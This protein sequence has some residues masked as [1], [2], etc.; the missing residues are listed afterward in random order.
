MGYIGYR[1][2]Q[3]ESPS[4]LF[5]KH[6]V[7]KI[8]SEVTVNGNVFE[9]SKIESAFFRDAFSDP[10]LRVRLFFESALQIMLVNDELRYGLYIVETFEALYDRTFRVRPFLGKPRYTRCHQGSI[11]Q[12]SILLIAAYQEVR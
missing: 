4:C 10:C 1:D 9:G 5:Y 2:I 8:F 11:L 7:V 3:N 12:L 6:S